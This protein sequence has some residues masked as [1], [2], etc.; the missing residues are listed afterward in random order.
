M[1]AAMFA[2]FLNL[3]PIYWTISTAL[4]NFNNLFLS[5]LHQTNN[6]HE[7]PYPGIYMAI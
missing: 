2:S 3:V 6:H 4:Q 7:T 5:T 1:P